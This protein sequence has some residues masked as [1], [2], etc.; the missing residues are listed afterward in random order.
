MSMEPL[1]HAKRRMLRRGTVGLLW[2][3]LVVAAV[4]GP[5]ALART[6]D[7]EQQIPTSSDA[8]AIATAAGLSA[9]RAQIGTGL[10]LTSVEFVSKG[11]WSVQAS[12]EG[13]LFSVGVVSVDGSA[14]AVGGVAR[15]PIEHVMSA[16]LLV[17]EVSEIPVDTND[18]V[19]QAVTGWVEGWLVGD[20]VS[21][22][23][24]PELDAAGVG[25]PYTSARVT[26]LGGLFARER[27]DVMLVRAQ[28]VTSGP[29]HNL[30]MSL[31]VIDRGD[32][33]WEVSEVLVA[34]PVG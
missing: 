10:V 30:E 3:L 17:A 31:V 5:V 20:A 18:P 13:A 1:S 9:M 8:L 19:T 25:V 7:I 2:V 14:V 4:S 11:Y 6:V 12:S 33:E 16:P 28:I 15:I 32:G 29:H 26:H 27:T 21:R 22:F 34:P 23:G 24:S